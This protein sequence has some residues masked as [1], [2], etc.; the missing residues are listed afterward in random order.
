M[1][2]LLIAIGFFCVVVFFT[3]KLYKYQKKVAKSKKVAFPPY[4]SLCPDY[5]K[6]IE[7]KEVID[8]KGR[9]GFAS[10]CKNVEKIGLCQ[11]GSGQDSIMDFTQGPY[12]GKNGKFFKCEWSKKCK[13]PWEGYDNLC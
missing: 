5:W 2:K 8:E 11:T 4:T 13:A 7:T 10:V 12:T 3:Y 9:P 1:N 6:V